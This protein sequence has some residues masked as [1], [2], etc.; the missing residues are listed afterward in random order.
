M[1]MRNRYA[2]GVNRSIYVGGL[3]VCSVL[4][5]GALTAACEGDPDQVIEGGAG[6]SGLE[7][8]DGVDGSD[9][10]DG[11]N[12][13][14][15]K[16]G[17]RGADGKNGKNGTNGQ[18]GATGLN[19]QD[20]NNGPNGQDGA[21][22][23]NGQDGTNGLNGQDGADAPILG[24]V[25]IF[26][27]TPAKK[28]VTTAELTFNF[29]CSAGDC[30][31]VVSV[32][33]AEFEE[34]APPFVLSGLAQGEHNIR[35]RA[36]S[37]DPEDEV[38]FGPVTS[39]AWTARRPNILSIVADDLGFSDLGVLGSEIDT[40]NLD[41]LANQGRLLTN[42][43]VGSVCA[44]TRAMLIS[45]TDNHKV[46]M[47][48]MG[49]P[50]DERRD[51]PGYE[52][53]LN[54]RSLSVAQLLQDGGYHTYIS[55]K[56]HLGSRIVGGT[57]GSGQ[58]PD[59]W[60]F[61][62][63]FTL[64]GGAAGNHYTHEGPAST[65]YVLDGAYSRPG[66]A[67][68]PEG[69]STDFYTDKLIEFIDDG[70]ADDP[71]K[72]FY[73]FAAY[74]APHWPLQAPEPWLSKYRGKYDVGYAPIAEARLRRL[75]DRGIFPQSLTP[76]P[77]VPESLTRFP[78]TPGNGTLAAQYVSAIHHA[79]DGYVD[80][81]QGPVVKDWESLTELERKAQARYMEIYAA[82]VDHL[83]YSI[84]RLIQHL[85]DI[86]EYE[87]TFIIFHSDSGAEGWP[88]NSGAD[89]LVT[90]ENN[91]SD[92]IFP[93]LGQDNGTANAR[94]I[95]YGIRW[96]EVSNTPLSYF[97]GFQSAGGLGAPA[98]V[99]LPGQ[100]KALPPIHH[101][102]HVTDDTATFLELAG[103]EPPSEPAP[104][105]IEDGVDRNA[106][107]VIYDERYVY[108]V[109][110]VSL[111]TALGQQSPERVHQSAFAGESYGRGFV[112]SAD[113]KWR[114]RFTEPPYGPLD[115]TWELY[116]IE[117]D[118]GE[119]YDLAAAYPEVLAG[120]I[121]QWKAY[122]EQVGGVSPLRPRGYY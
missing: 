65:S 109:T 110:G 50:T 48:T 3:N 20:G 51:L 66:N 103:V 41:A 45:G 105:L 56:W 4:L 89:P 117:Q 111:L 83:D 64:L 25:A 78:A 87:Y 26:A 9:G 77:G 11:R 36:R 67:G 14:N 107:K 75:K 24:P 17:R 13:S 39:Y 6:S 32:D 18:D 22:G 57:T 16:E 116:Y 35:I 43:Q 104:P 99:H 31:Y 55:G 82:M 30:Q 93:T 23:L 101:F 63:S 59:Q 2:T 84:G 74:T 19:G 5:L 81:G 106:G 52:G 69:Y 112:L 90:D 100:T 34:A 58:T 21:N 98:I 88:I 38:G 8:R 113:G 95:K 122:L 68:H 7:G 62:R 73:A 118:R 86:G 96:A 12:G 33:D 61:E 29:G 46:G 119:V 70:L 47:G 60:G 108:P 42:H 15:G 94:N 27:E 40:P 102:T 1:K 91:A 121:E 44:I 72:P 53:Y 37:A 120:L 71:E 28:V 54:D 10:K 80:Y 76:N 92:A 114:A 97:K 79:D 49:A 115:G 85:K